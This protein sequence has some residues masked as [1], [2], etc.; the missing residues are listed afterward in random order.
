M[1]TSAADYLRRL[2]SDR[3][4]DLP[5]TTAGTLRLDVR[6]DGHTEHWY[7]TIADQRV[8]V[9]RSA[10]EADLVVRADR[11]VFDQLAT[12]Q[13]HPAE[14]MERNEATV[15]GDIRLF[16]LLRRIFPGPAGARHPRKAAGKR[17]GPR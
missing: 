8:Q 5:D 6:E 15:Q 2:G 17:S 14:A 7:L 11:A 16:M 1:T 10:D 13:L 9:T 4:P 3:R 12:G